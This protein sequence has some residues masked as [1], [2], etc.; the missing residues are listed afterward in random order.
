VVNK[1]G[2]EELAEINEL[3]CMYIMELGLPF[4]LS[5]LRMKLYTL[6][7]IVLGLDARYYFFTSMVPRKTGHCKHFR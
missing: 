5:F 1:V 7:W 3:L 6:E 2:G 4:K